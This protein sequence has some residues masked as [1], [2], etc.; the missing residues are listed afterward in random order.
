MKTLRP[1][2]RSVLLK[3]TGLGYHVDKEQKLGLVV[4]SDYVFHK[5]AMLGPWKGQDATLSH[6][7]S[8][9]SFARPVTLERIPG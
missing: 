3:V 1:T 6:L 8:M 4:L 5:A 7:G 9:V 2:G